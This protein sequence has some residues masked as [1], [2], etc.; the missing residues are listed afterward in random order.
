ME[1]AHKRTYQH[2]PPALSDNKPSH[3]VQF[4]LCECSKYFFYLRYESGPLYRP[5]SRD[6]ELILKE[7]SSQEAERLAAIWEYWEKDSESEG[8][9]AVV[10]DELHPDHIV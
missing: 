5:A 6:F 1:L 3:Q 9:A 7:F 2:Y 4:A 8:E 10:E